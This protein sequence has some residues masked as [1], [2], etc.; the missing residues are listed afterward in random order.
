MEIRKGVVDRVRETKKR[1]YQDPKDALK[2]AY[3]NKVVMKGVDWACYIVEENFATH[4]S[5]EK[6]HGCTLS[7]KRPKKNP[8]DRISDYGDFMEHRFY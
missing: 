6:K 2:C 5:C 7:G 1:V 8:F 4:S 3:C